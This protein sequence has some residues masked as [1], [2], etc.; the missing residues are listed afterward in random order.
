MDTIE[1]DIKKNVDEKINVYDQYLKASYAKLAKLTLQD[2]RDN[3]KESVFFAKYTKENIVNWLKSPET[4]QKQLRTACSF[5]YV[6]SNHFRRLINYFAKMPLFSYIIVPYGSD[7]TK[8]NKKMFKSAYNKVVNATS[9]MNIPHEFQKVLTVAFREDVFYGYCYE[10]PDSF[11]IKQLPSDFCKIFKIED[12]VYNPAFDF[13]FFNSGKEKPELY[14]EEFVQKYNAYRGTN[15]KNGDQSLRWQELDSTSSICI[16]LNEEINFVIPPFAGVLEALFDIEDFKALQKAKTE[17]DNTKLIAFKLATNKDTN[18][19]QMDDVM[20]RM[21]YTEISEQ[22][23]ERVGFVITPFETTDHNFER[24]NVGIDTVSLAE[25]QY[26]NSTG[27]SNMIFN[28]N[29][30]SSAALE[31]SIISDFDIVCGVL[32]QIERWINRRIKFMDS[33]Y[34]FA[35]KILDVSRYNQ[36]AMFK[37]YRDACLNG[38]PMKMAMAATL[39]YSP[40]D[41]INMGMLENDVL[42]LRNTV[43][44]QPFLSSNTLSSNDVGGRPEKD[45]GDLSDEGVKTKD[46]GANENRV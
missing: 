11:F 30:A 28:G 5:L 18:E 36:D 43:F 24:S 37:A 15:G 17:L 44:S 22:L 34:R 10:T 3:R 9:N 23:P 1:E 42:Q 26:F 31:K 21:F 8:I 32:R 12:G 41:T 7:D 40:S 45:D 19:I 4:S 46:S 38:S 20:R 16:K 25:N 27:V 39:G 33:K 29:K 13:S 35:I 6:S 14:G 2:L